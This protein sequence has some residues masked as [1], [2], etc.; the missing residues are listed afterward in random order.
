MDE[1]VCAL[2]KRKK[3]LRQSHIIPKFVV[4][5]LKETSTTGYIRQ[6]I[7]PNMRQQ[8]LF[9]KPLLCGDCEEKFSNIEKKFCENIFISFQNGKKEFIYD[10]WLIDF[11]I[12]LSW[13]VA[14]T[15]IEELGGQYLPNLCAMQK[16]I[17]T[18]RRYLNDESSNRGKYKHHIFFL[19]IL[20]S[21]SEGVEIVEKTNWYFLRSIDATIA[22]SKINEFVYTKL[23]GIIFVSYVIPFNENG[24]R[25]TRVENKGRLKIPQACG[26]TGFGEFLNDRI[27]LT[28]KLAGNISERQKEKIGKDFMKNF[29]G[30]IDSKSI[31]VLMAD[32]EL[33]RIIEGGEGS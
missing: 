24:W 6:G 25:N 10:K 1:K 8:D 27:K 20:E 4:R 11:I 3:E 15:E 28:N 12:S 9:K 29:E 14:F 32:L 23:P 7:K 5:W 13:R 19:D 31:Q 21:A 30:R 18:W 22:Y 17:E 2:C 26:A 33:K 16:A